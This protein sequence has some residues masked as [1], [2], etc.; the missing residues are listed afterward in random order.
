MVNLFGSLNGPSIPQSVHGRES[1]AL[2]RQRLRIVKLLEENGKESKDGSS[3]NIS[4]LTVSAD[5]NIRGSAFLRYNFRHKPFQL[6]DGDIILSPETFPGYF[7]PRFIQALDRLQELSTGSH[8]AIAKAAE[9]E[10][11]R[12]NIALAAAN[13]LNTYAGLGDVLMFDAKRWVGLEFEGNVTHRDKN[14]ITRR[15][16]SSGVEYYS[17]TLKKLVAESDFD[18]TSFSAD[19]T[20][21]Y[22]MPRPQEVT[23]SSVELV[24][25]A[26]ASA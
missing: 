21:I 25:S 19:V 13:K 2:G 17:K 26:E 22:P 20:T 3:L 7:D 23:G 12:A 9:R 5:Q 18:E 16:A 15:A 24:D 4:F 8:R 1:L 6:K 10:L 14:N 11:T